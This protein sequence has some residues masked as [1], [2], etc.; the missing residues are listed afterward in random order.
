MSETADF[1]LQL[2]EQL[3]SLAT[4]VIGDHKNQFR[5]L[6][7]NFR[8][9]NKW[10]LNTLNNSLG[11]LENNFNQKIR[12]IMPERKSNL[13]QLQQKF[14]AKLKYKLLLHKLHYN[15]LQQALPVSART[16]VKKQ[17]SK[18][19]V[20]DALISAYNPVN[21]LKRG[22][23]ITYFKGKALYSPVL[24]VSGDLIETRLAEGCIQSKVEN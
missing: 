11:F 4:T 5:E 6:V 23:S 8:N 15:R 24:L 7:I 3:I 1:L 10:Q 13:N 22:Y 20:A 19:Q 12:H 14:E 18:T 16:F 9:L 17:K 2:E 21:I